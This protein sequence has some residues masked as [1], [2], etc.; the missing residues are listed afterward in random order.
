MKT[1]PEI[2]H[3]H[4][5]ILKIS[6]VALQSRVTLARNCHCVHSKQF[7]GK[8]LRARLHAKLFSACI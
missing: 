5:A 3:T 1:D 8:Y 4:P 2:F 7:V 6:Q